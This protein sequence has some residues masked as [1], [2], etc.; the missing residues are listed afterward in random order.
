MIHLTVFRGREI[1][2][3]HVRAGGCAG[4][5][6]MVDM[7]LRE[8]FRGAPLVVECDTPRHAD[9]VVVTGSLTEPLSEAALAVISQAPATSRLLL[10]GD[11]A[12]GE[13]PIAGESPCTDKTVGLEPELIRGCPVTVESLLKG[14]LHVTR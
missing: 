9:T 8:R 5:G 4:C 14:V 6:E 3:F 11:C 7:F 13:G 12:L 1:S 10:V 2:V